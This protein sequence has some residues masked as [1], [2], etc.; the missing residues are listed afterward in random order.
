M[1]SLSILVRSWPLPDLAPDR[2]DSPTALVRRLGLGGATITNI[3]AMIGI[4]PFI[5]I[6]L[7]L[8]T[9]RGPQ[10]MLGWVIGATVAICDGLVWA[11]L[12]AAIPRS[13]GGYHYLLES[14]G[15]NGLG[16]LMSFL[17]LWQAVALTPLF[18]GSGAVGFAR[19]SMY[20][21]PAMTGG[22]ARLLAIGVCVVATLLI[23]RRIDGV[24]RWGTVFGLII[25]GEALWI[26]VDGALN[27]G[28]ARLDV[29]A[30]AFDM[31]RD[32]WLGLG[33]ATLYAMYDYAGYQTV[34]SVGGEVLRPAVT[35]P[36]SIVLATMSVATL[37]FAMNLSILTVMP[38]QDA[39]R[40]QFVVS[41]FIARIHGAGAASFM[42]LLI[43][44]TTLAGVFAGMLGASRIP[45]AAAANGRFFRVFAY[46]HPTRQFPAFSVL[47]V[48]G[49]SA[50]CCLLDLDD[51][52]Q[53]ATVISILI[54]AFPMLGAVVALRRNRP[55][56]DRPF[57]IWLYPVPLVVALTGWSYIL[58][59]T[60]MI[61]I[62]AGLVLLAIGIVAYL[63]RARQASEWPWS[64]TLE[65]A[66]LEVRS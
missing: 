33:G 54:V 18:M 20:L 60:G 40:S 9:M 1:P 65:A 2:V 35:I 11:E 55:E 62:A 39:M 42:T 37:Y 19:Y 27:L 58:S 57:R 25:L 13:G 5:T 63:W 44:V 12:G 24:G 56:I 26:V 64:T 41:D 14:Y 52:I 28:G 34:C 61:Y 10:A 23:Y 15:P 66:K 45:Y 49:A 3:L 29:P 7:L 50:L 8:G 53:A 31:S 47:F 38:W 21:Y 59:T 46:L 6:P 43:L 17:Y 32:F 16:R 36:R 48:G 22:Q 51:L 30:D 4:G